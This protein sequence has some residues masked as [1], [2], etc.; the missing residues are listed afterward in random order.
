[1]KN[2]AKFLKPHLSAILFLAV[3]IA[4]LTATGTEYLFRIGI[5]GGFWLAYILATN[6]NKEL[7]FHGLMALVIAVVIAFVAGIVTTATDFHLLEVTTGM[8][9]GGAFGIIFGLNKG[10]VS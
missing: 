5:I 6:Q 2:L 4:F 9:F 7:Q 8:V 3:G 1:M 10:V